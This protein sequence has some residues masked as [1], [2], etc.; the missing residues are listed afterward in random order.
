MWLCIFLWLLS[1]RWWHLPQLNP[2][3]ADGG[4]AEG[5]WLSSGP[6]LG[7]YLRMNFRLLRPWKRRDAQTA[8]WPPATSTLRRRGSH[9]HYFTVL[10]LKRTHVHKMPGGT[11]KRDLTLYFAEGSHSERVA[12]GVVADLHPAFVLLLLPL[13]HL[14]R[15]RRLGSRCAGFADRLLV[16]LTEGRG[17]SLLS[18]RHRWTRTVSCTVRAVV[19]KRKTEFICFL[20][21]SVS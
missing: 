21:C 5:V 1:S 18:P 17:P 16:G 3:A 10:H 6:I 14:L 7:T 12:E 9:D 15:Y 19:E 4:F 2:V 11:Q 20:E 8:H 13:C